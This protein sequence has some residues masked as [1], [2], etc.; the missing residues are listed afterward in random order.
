MTPRLVFYDGKY[1]ADLRI[2]KILGR[3]NELGRKEEGEVHIEVMREIIE[4]II[5]GKIKK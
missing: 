5:E 1:R 2:D 3:L 4:R